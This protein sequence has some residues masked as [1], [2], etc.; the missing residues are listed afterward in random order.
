VSYSQQRSVSLHFTS[1]HFAYISSTH[2]LPIS[3]A[4]HPQNNAAG[5]QTTCAHLSMSGSGVSLRS[6]PSSYRHAHAHDEAQGR[7]DDFHMAWVLVWT[8]IVSKQRAYGG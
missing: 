8:S 3:V 2:F 4:Q 5:Q 7:S 6:C 1:L